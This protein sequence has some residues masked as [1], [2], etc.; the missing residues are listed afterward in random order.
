MFF[1]NTNNIN[2]TCEEIERLLY[3]R[4]ENQT[5]NK[6]RLKEYFLL[7]DDTPEKRKHIYKDYIVYV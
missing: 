6:K 7:L 2:H 5:I 4:Q 1:V 3:K